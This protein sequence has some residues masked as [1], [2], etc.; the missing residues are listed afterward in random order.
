[1]PML[2]NAFHRDGELLHAG[3]VEEVRVGAEKGQRRR[4]EPIASALP[5][6][7]ALGDTA[8]R[9]I[10]TAVPI[11]MKPSMVENERTLRKSYIQPTSG[12]WAT[13]G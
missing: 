2:Y 10:S 8:R 6:A 11:S 9:A 3:Q 7:E 12:L 4:E 5:R 1:M 13:S